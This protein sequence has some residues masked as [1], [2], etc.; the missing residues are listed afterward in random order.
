MKKIIGALVIAAGI[1]I[2]YYLFQAE[3]AILGS[4]IALAGLIL[5]GRMFK[6]D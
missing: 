4:I 1:I 5:G 2:A 3:H 6:A